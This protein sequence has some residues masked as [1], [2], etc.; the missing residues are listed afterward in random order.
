MSSVPQPAWSRVLDRATLVLAALAG[1]SLIFMVVMIATGVI[2]RYVFGRP[3][4]GSNEI[5]QM[6]AVALVMLALPYCTARRGH[7][8]VDVFDAAIGR[9][10]RFIGDLLSRLL[11]GFVLAVLVFR[12]V[13]KA[14]DAHR[15][16]DATNMLGLPIWPFYAILAAGMACCILV[17]TAQLIPVL[18]GKGGE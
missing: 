8:C 4:L 2:A 7:V 15:Y 18:V 9:W 12:A 6:T 13:L 1:C 10:G 5:V 14:L 17:L 16:G 3:I 11:S